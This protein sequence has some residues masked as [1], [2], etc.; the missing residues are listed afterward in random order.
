MTLNQQFFQV[1]AF[2][3]VADMTPK[4]GQIIIVTKTPHFRE[5][6]IVLVTDGSRTIGQL[7]EEWR[8]NRASSQELMVAITAEEQARIT[9][10]TSLQHQITALQQAANRALV[11]DDHA[12]LAAWMV[13]GQALTAPNPPYKPSDL[14]IGWLA[15]FRSTGEADQWW[16]GSKWLDQEIHLDLSGYYTAEEQ[17]AKFAPLLSPKFR[18]I[19]EVPTP[20][21]TV[22]QQA[23]P[24]SELSWLVNT[25]RDLLAGVRRKYRLYEID[26]PLEKCRQYEKGLILR[27]AEDDIVEQGEGLTKPV[28]CVNNKGIA[29]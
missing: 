5:A 4:G 3:P 16:D 11:F 15:L 24:V 19:P 14:Q 8:D 18:G 17:D 25:V 2:G 28:A 20:D 9:A 10:D 27:K 22:P 12:A 13:S 23:V 7:Y 29:D 21:Y 26:R 1:Y 6:H